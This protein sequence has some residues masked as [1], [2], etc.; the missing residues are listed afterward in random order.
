MSSLEK[1][2]DNELTVH[3]TALNLMIPNK[4]KRVHE[5]YLYFAAHSECVFKTIF[6]MQPN[7]KS[8]FSKHFSLIIV[9]RKKV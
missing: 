4:N 2:Y 8:K 3:S 9:S 7:S 5:R 1:M 6:I